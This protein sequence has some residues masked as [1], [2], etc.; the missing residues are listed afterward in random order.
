MAKINA[1]EE[2]LDLVDKN[3]RAIGSVPISKAN[4]DPKSIHREVAVIIYDDKNRVLIQQRS[5]A[6]R[7]DPGV[8][9]V[10]CAGHVTKGLTPLEAAH[11][12]LKEEVGFDT[13]LNF[14]EK[15]FNKIP[16]ETRFFYWY[17]GKL[18]KK[19]R[20]KIEP[21]EVE[22]V[23]FLGQI[24][25]QEFLK[26]EEKIGKHSLKYLNKFWSNKL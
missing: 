1:T 22:K 8:W 17:V 12:E 26:S 14:V 9:T 2:V 10:T 25:L 5:F 24:K 4:S 20:I 16:T 6:K 3:D 13:K 18:P 19:A 15:E 7:L 21:R 11:T 23:M